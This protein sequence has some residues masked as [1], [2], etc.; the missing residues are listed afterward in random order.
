MG[1]AMCMGWQLWRLRLVGTLWGGAMRGE[2]GA[3]ESEGQGGGGMQGAGGGA[4]VTGCCARRPPPAARTRTCTHH[5]GTP[6]GRKEELAHHII[7]DLA[8]HAACE[9]MVW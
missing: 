7:R 4:A 3:R 6:A 8:M 2:E 9:E 5:T 1:K